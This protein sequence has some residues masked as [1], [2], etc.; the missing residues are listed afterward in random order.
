M[1][2]KFTTENFIKKAKLIYGDKYDYSKT[3]YSKAKNKIIVICPLHGEFLQRGDHFLNGHGCPKCTG[4][5]KNTK[6]L[7]EQFKLVHGETYNY[8]LVD[9]V[10][11]KTKIKIICP[12]HGIFEI[13]SRQ[14]IRGVNC[15]K[16]EHER[17]RLL[18]TKTTEQF[19]E[20]AI[21]T[22]NDTY[23]YSLVK[24]VNA[25]TPVTIIC[26]K[27]GKFNQIPRTHIS[28]AG[29]P[30]CKESKGE[31]K[32][33]LFLEKEGVVFIHQHKFDDCR[34]IRPLPF[35]FY[36][37]TYNLCIEYQGEQHYINKPNWGG[38]NL[39]YVKQNDEIK[40]QYCIKNNINILRIHYKEFNNIE[41]I[42]ENH[43]SSFNNL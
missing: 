24:Y 19:I 35:D 5:N 41:D 14:H 7:I 3:I 12:K 31:R 43:L 23:N 18:E 26:T 42:L 39:N 21:L 40:L 22:H 38:N 15:G 11:A 17:I 20:N 6:E 9:Y 1:K 13:H 10:N 32:I 33:R 27:H 28:G 4:F 8:S 16:C 29:C 36:L 34:N 25:K 30:I 2:E 37:P